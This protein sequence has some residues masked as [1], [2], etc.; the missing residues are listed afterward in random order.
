MNKYISFVLFFI[1]VLLIN[2]FFS[3]F[4]KAFDLTADKRH[5][6]SSESKKIL[7]NLDDVIY[8]KIYLDGSFPS[9]FKH[10]Q[11]ELLS[12]L[13]SFKAISN[14]NID[15]VL[16]NPNKSDD[17]F[18]KESLFKQLVKNGLK[19]TDVE[20]RSNSKKTNQIIFPG[21][22]I[23]YKGKT[24]AI[25]FLKNSIN[26]R[27][28]ENINSSIEN[29]EF[30]FISAFNKLIRNN[31]YDIAF[32]E[33]NGELE[34]NEVY[35]L[36]ESVYN[37][38]N[39]LSFY[40]NIDRFNIKQFFV[41]STSNQI[42]I[43][44]QITALNKYKIVVIANPTV[45]FNMLEKFIIDQ[46]LMNGGK[47]IW[48]VDGVNASMD[49]LNNNNFFIA[50][51]KN[52]N[53]DDMLYKYGVRINSDLIEDLRSTQIPV[54]TGYSNN[55]PQQS[56]FSWPYFPLVFSESFH[57][58][59]KGLDAIKCN[60]VSSID[61]IENAI[62]KTILLTSSKKSRII[63]SPAKISLRLLENNL[64]VNSY[65]ESYIPISVLLEG[66]FESVFKNRIVPK[67]KSLEFKDKSVNTQMIVIS[68]GDIARN[69]V[70]ESGNISPL[71]YDPFIK[72]TY[73]GNKIFL[74][75]AIHFLCDDIGL[76]N[77][78]LKE[79]DLRLLD[80]EKISKFKLLVQYVNIFS[81]LLLL[82]I[83]SFLFLYFKKKK[84]A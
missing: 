28:G 47:I 74:T 51:R 46:Y 25:N 29:L 6:I 33:G 23:S 73:S 5:S 8:I 64:P 34:F 54:V 21:A 61:T 26:K 52:L 81:P 3:T 59:S 69:N 62:K 42:D 79:L 16:I 41:D 20:V 30:E 57:P 13:T 32:L 72:F 2:I 80:K 78:K 19:P 45:P 18:E 56:F 48:L 9:Q 36:T 50:T 55:I 66:N 39:R 67:Y 7:Q 31:K 49:S 11:E 75:N 17:G 82:S 15:F 38:N 70:S 58:I 4:D 43:S 76:A 60:F 24:Q 53:I 84:Y 77:L 68:D 40:Y 71:G 27:P 63:R 14:Q 65:N 83:F 22:L 12:M 1:L 44:K 10:L 37:D 35:D